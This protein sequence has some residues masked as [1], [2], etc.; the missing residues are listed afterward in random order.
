MAERAESVRW[1]VDMASSVVVCSFVI[2]ADQNG[3]ATISPDSLASRRA[4]TNP[5]VEMLLR[6]PCRKGGDTWNKTK[7]APR[8]SLSIQFVSGAASPSG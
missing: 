5:H 6:T 7:Q 3:L 4:C 2:D 8:G 1:R